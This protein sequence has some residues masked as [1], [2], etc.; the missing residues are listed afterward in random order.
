MSRQ[1]SQDRPVLV[2][3]VISASMTRTGTPPK[4]DSQ[5]PSGRRRK[6]GSLGELFPVRTRIRKPA[7]VA[8]ISLA[9]QP[10]AKLRSASSSIPACRLASSG[11]VQVVSPMET[12]R[13][14]ASMTVR[15]PQLTRASSRSIG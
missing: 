10:A 9:S 8:A 3:M 7:L 12:G 6:T 4:R 13:N 14:T 15:V 2:V 1:P 11:G 5:E